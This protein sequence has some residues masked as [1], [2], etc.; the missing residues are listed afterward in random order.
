MISRQ[1]IEVIFLFMFDLIC[2]Q[3]IHACC[4]KVSFLRLSFQAEENIFK[5]S[6]I[7]KIK[8]IIQSIQHSGAETTR[9][10]IE[11]R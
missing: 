1:V 9:E 3:F 6:F 7:V 4:N 10:T 8:P 11:E 5:Q 2:S